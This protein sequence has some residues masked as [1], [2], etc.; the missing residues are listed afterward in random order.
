MVITV[1]LTL[2]VHAAYEL[3]QGDAAPASTGSAVADVT[4]HSVTTDSASSD[5][6]ATLRRIIAQ[7]QRFL[8]LWRAEWLASDWEQ[9][10]TL[11]QQVRRDQNPRLSAQATALYQCNMSRSPALHDTSRAGSIIVSAHFWRPMC[12]TWL[13]E[14]GHVPDAGL[15]LDSALTPARRAQIGVARD[16]LLREL[17]DAVQSYPGDNWLI[18]QWIRF[19]LDQAY[20][21]PGYA[22]QAKTA[23]EGCRA[24]PWWC[25]SLQAL[26]HAKQGRLDSA[27]VGFAMARRMMPDSLRCITGNVV[28]LMDRR[29][30]PR[31]LSLPQSCEQMLELG[32]RY[33][34]LADPFW[35]DSLNER[36]VE[37]DVRR[38]SLLLVATLPTSERFD[39]LPANGADA[40]AQMIQR[41]G[42]PTK[43]F[44]AGLVQTRSVPT[45]RG[46]EVIRF[47]VGTDPFDRAPR[48]PLTS[49]EYSPDR[50]HLGPSWSALL[51]PLSAQR[52]DWELEAPPSTDQTAWWPVEHAKL[53]RRLLPLQEWQIQQWRRPDSAE[54]VVAT[55]LPPALLQEAVPPA[56]VAATLIGAAAPGLL[57]QIAAGEHAAGDRIVLHGKVPFDSTLLSLE[58]R[59]LRGFRQDAR[60]RFAVVA[61]PALSALPQRGLALSTP[62]LLFVVPSSR[63]TRVNSE[64]ATTLLL[65]STTLS[66]GT[67]VGLYWETYGLA[68]S[69]SVSTELHVERLDSP[70]VFERIRVAFGVASDDASGVRIRWNDVRPGEPAGNGAGPLAHGRYLELAMNELLPGDY[71]LTVTVRVVDGRT[72]SNY[73]LFTIDR[74]PGPGLR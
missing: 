7:E 48:P 37:H 47:R 4:A 21:G 15:V 53:G 41:Y 24:E 51:S 69:D 26:V 28:P 73:R 5:S 68:D 59:G 43:M 11:Q 72:V 14:H 67:P 35:A 20:R 23:A 33:W 10:T 42:W 65:A 61:E 62:A 49:Q 19:L 40:V 52:D 74:A 71:A 60:A 16:S 54:L 31:G 44:W 34:W 25:T 27:H 9:W 38:L 46:T 22:A 8:A 45:A 3:R 29:K 30:A 58:V 55:R 32:E 39:W 66:R 50:V 57:R 2:F 6:L 63:T 17:A 18:G 12:P 56:G 64:V 36:R 1:L 13:L 70:G